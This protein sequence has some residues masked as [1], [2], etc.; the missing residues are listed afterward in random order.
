MGHSARHTAQRLRLGVPVGRKPGW[1]AAGTEGMSKGAFYN[2]QARTC[3]ASN[4]PAKD[5]GATYGLCGQKWSASLWVMPG[6]HVPLSLECLEPSDSQWSK[7]PDI[8]QNP[9]LV[10]P[11]VG[12]Q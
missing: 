1:A 7:H 9:V 3:P 6:R 2:L 11:A 4:A 12:T 10:S 5:S 8:V